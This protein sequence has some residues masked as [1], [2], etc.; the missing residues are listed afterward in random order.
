MKIKQKMKNWIVFISAVILF[1]FFYIF[2]AL[3]LGSNVRNNVSQGAISM[4][5]AFLKSETRAIDDRISNLCSD[6]SCDYVFEEGFIKCS[7]GKDE[8][9]IDLSSLFDPDNPLLSSVSISLP[10]KWTWEKGSASRGDI[11]LSFRL[12]KTGL[13]IIYY[14]SSS[15]LVSSQEK[16]ISLVVRNMIY[17]AILFITFIVGMAIYTF[18][19]EPFAENKNKKTIDRIL[20]AVTEDFV[21][22]V[23][24]DVR[25]RIE[26]VFFLSNGPRPKWTGK[27][28]TYDENIKEYAEKIVAPEDRAR[29][30]ETVEFDSLMNYFK[31]SGNE[32][33]IEYDVIIDGERRRYQGK[34]TFSTQDPEGVKIYVGVR[35][36]TK[37][38]EERT[39]YNRRLMSALAEAEEANKGKSYFLFNMSHD[40]RTPLNAVI[41][42]SEL[43]K[44]HLDDKEVLEDYIDKIQ[45]C[46]NQLLGLIGDVLDMAKIESGKIDLSLNPCLCQDMMNEVV[47]SVNESAKEKGLSFEASGNAC[48]TTILCDKVKVQKILLN[49]LSNAVKYTPG[50]GKVTLSVHEEIKGDGDL[51]DFTFVIRDNGIGISKEFLPYVFNSFSRERNATLSGV[52]GTGLGMT[53]TKRLV[54]AMGGKIE[55][56]S[57]QGKGTTVTVFLT[58]KRFEN[59]VIEKK[60]EKLPE[61]S[62]EGK[63]VLLAED[64][65]I[66]SEIASEMLREVGISTEVV[67]NGEECVNALLSHS[68]GYYDL[69]L[70]D[71]QMPVMDGY[72]ATRTIRRFQDKD[73]RMIP[74]IAMT[75][76]VFEEDKEKAYQSGMNG[77]LSKPID[78]ALLISTLNKCLHL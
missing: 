51:S 61:I 6:S 75:A 40:I 68:A 15:Y 36:I 62:L 21:F 10:G 53:I 33:S 43:A 42:Y 45:I 3:R 1:F 69:V 70:M 64:N 56:E 39:E 18:N 32:V 59:K 29:F 14:I 77:H 49:I 65:E 63:R 8:E 20:S 13:E 44:K 37:I 30:L 25:T 34:F 9:V 16:G 52:S 28:K 50:G 24:V 11:A 73:K 76:N 4:A 57:E 46:G 5:S 55:I 31:K 72:E 48:H 7:L 41:G 35:D 60:E 22:L 12:E 2:F 19:R 23:V 26:K 17:V 54:D 58:F 27:D 78:M 67:T 74:V 66:N 71:V 47:V 38:E